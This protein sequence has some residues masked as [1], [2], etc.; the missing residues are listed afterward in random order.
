MTSQLW[1]VGVVC[2]TLEEEN[3]RILDELNLY[4]VVSRKK[5][6]RKRMLE[7]EAGISV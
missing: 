7:D 6:E 3:T 5:P 4:V 2:F 1:Y